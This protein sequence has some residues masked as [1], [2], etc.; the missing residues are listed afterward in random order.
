MPKQKHILVVDDVPG[1]CDLME[2]FL[3]NRGYECRTAGTSEEALEIFQNFRTDVILSD[4]D[5]PGMNGLELTRNVL[6]TNPETAVILMTGNGDADMVVQALRLGASDYLLKPF[7]FKTMED[8][9]KQAISKKH[10]LHENEH[11]LVTLKERLLEALNSSHEASEKI[12][13]SFCKTLEM[14]DIETYS[15][16]E[17]VSNYSLRLARNLGLPSQEREVVRIGALLHDVGK[18]A[19]PDRIL[20]KAGPLTD[21]EWNIMRRHVDAGF[22]IVSGIPGLEKAAQIVLQH[23]E[24]YGGAGYPN[25]LQGD[26]I[27]IGARIFVVADTYDAITSNRPYRVAR[28]DAAARA[29]ILKYVGTQFDPTIVEAFSEIPNEEWC[30]SANSGDKKPLAVC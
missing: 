26:E 29:E 14:R 13:A 20:L 1:V 22:R 15:H 19:V 17:R 23:H 12:M 27:C 25:G 2:T 11:E 9:I 30:Q 10:Q 3:T 5:M 16:M 6:N 18:V 28:S 24:Q 8:S 21:Q 7:D 4:I